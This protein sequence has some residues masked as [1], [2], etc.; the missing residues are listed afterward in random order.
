[1]SIATPTPELAQ[2]HALAP[3]YVARVRIAERAAAAETTAEGRRDQSERAELL[4]AAALAEAERIT[5]TREVQGYER[6]IELATSARAQAERGV[7][8]RQAAHMRE[9][10][11][12]RERVEAQQMFAALLRVAEPE[13]KDRER[14][15]GFLLQRA[16]AVL[17]VAH[18]LGAEPAELDRAA[19]QL[20]AARTAS[21]PNRVR[22]GQTALLAANAALGSARAHVDSA[23]P[24]E[25]RDLVER[26]RERG[27]ET[28]TA[29]LG[30]VTIELVLPKGRAD[31]LRR[32]ALVA[33][34]LPAFPHGPIVLT[35]GRQA[36]ATYTGCERAAWLFP[37]ERAR[38]RVQPSPPEL[39]P[40]AVRVSLPAYGPAAK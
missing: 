28:S 7:I 30:P 16:Q 29:E 17:A 19:L 9:V 21:L 12:Q 2:V 24:D 26:L 5:L 39:P 38:V 36:A 13:P 4:R 27:F 31:L 33:E 20:T 10:S 35:C 32:F 18:V 37:A 1:V 34:L 15:W 11:A 6:R 25:Q 8:E 14:I 22:L 3:D 40:T 23:S